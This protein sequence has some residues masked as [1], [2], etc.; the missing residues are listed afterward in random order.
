MS[1]IHSTADA[2]AHYRPLRVVVAPVLCALVVPL[3]GSAHAGA[4]PAP[5]RTCGPASNDRQATLRTPEPSPL[6]H[7]VRYYTYCGSAKAVVRHHGSTLELHPGHCVFQAGHFRAV[8]IGVLAVRDAAAMPVL[9]I[10][11]RPP[12]AG[13]RTFNLAEQTAAGYVHA[14]VHVPGT[15][16]SNAES[17][18]VTFN[19]GMRSGT[20]AVRVSGERVTGSWTCG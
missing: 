10:T 9:V 11:M 14:F 8:G 15:L 2:L 4:S 16:G 20:F 5:P 19:S 1:S 7:A 3:G 13:A 12:A 17:G 18:T 6:S